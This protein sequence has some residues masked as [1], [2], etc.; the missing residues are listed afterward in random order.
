[1]RR[2]L[3]LV[4]EA[5]V[6]LVVLATLLF[7]I[8]RLVPGDPALVVLGD[9]ADPAVA[10]R[11]R[12]T[13]GL[14]GPKW[15]QY[16]HFMERMA[17]L[18]F[19]ESLRRP[20]IRA[21]DQVAAAFVPTFQLATLATVLAGTVGTALAILRVGPWLG[22]RA[23]WVERGVAVLASF[24]LLSFAPLVTYALALRLRVVPLPGDPDSGWVGRV[25]PA[26]LLA[27][28]MAAHVARIGMVSLEDVAAKSFVTVARAK[29]LSW[30][31]VW[32]A[33]ALPA[34]LAALLSVI[35]AQLGALLGGA[36]VVERLF[37]RRGLGTLILDAYASR[38][39]PVM[40]GA[41]LLSAATFVVTQT[42]G[43]VLHILIDPRTRA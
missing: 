38:D 15:L 43:R 39:V 37:E 25:Y 2:S 23:R 28:P 16:A 19:G 18:D 9:H 5:L 12:A 31:R 22:E 14:T 33:H 21:R 11:L 32:L 24:P 3:F 1:M 30:T 6:I 7:V 10:E 4:G 29:G 42:A 34:S 40:E 41:L 13:L 8:T 17:T 36:V 35:T 20:G 27:L 26:C